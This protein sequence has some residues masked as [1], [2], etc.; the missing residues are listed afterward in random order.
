MGTFPTPKQ[1]GAGS[2]QSRTLAWR[3]SVEKRE[4]RKVGTW[5]E[6]HQAAMA[7]LYVLRKQPDLNRR[8]N[9]NFGR[10][11][12]GHKKGAPDMDAPKLESLLLDVSKQV[13]NQKETRPGSGASHAPSRSGDFLSPSMSM[14]QHS[15]EK[16]GFGERGLRQSYPYDGMRVPSAKLN[17]SK[18]A[19]ARPKSNRQFGAA[20]CFLVRVH[21]LR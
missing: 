17:R 11:K 1:E 4:A 12:P 7:L 19:S 6:N 15:K 2:P 21:K 14:N 10:L 5:V 20:F 8:P 18:R 3:L 13:V 16:T 9:L